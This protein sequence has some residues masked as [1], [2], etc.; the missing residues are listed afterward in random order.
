MNLVE[1]G[2]EDR[3]GW[4][5]PRVMSHGRLWNWWCWTCGFCYQDH[6]ATGT[7]SFSENLNLHFSLPSKHIPLAVQCGVEDCTNMKKYCC[8]KTGMQL[9]SLECY[10]KNIARIGS[11][12]GGT[13]KLWMLFITFFMYINMIHN[14]MLKVV[15]DY[16]DSLV[17][18]HIYLSVPLAGL[19]LKFI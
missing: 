10:R 11:L 13:F 7:F 18:A 5:W 6:L 12:C 3:D 8:S 4:N 19:D 16:H 1:T 14:F 9:C 15:C 17:P 2:F